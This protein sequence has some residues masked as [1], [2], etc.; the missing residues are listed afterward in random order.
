MVS[1]IEE[2]R[3][4]G[5]IMVKPKVVRDVGSANNALVYI[6]MAWRCEQETR[7][8]TIT[9]SRNRIWWAVK[10]RQM[11][12]ETGLN[13][14]QIR[15]SLKQLADAGWVEV[16]E[17]GPGLIRAYR[18]IGHVPT[19]SEQSD[20]PSDQSDSSGS[21]PSEQSDLL[22]SIETVAS[23]G[24]DKKTGVDADSEFERCYPEWFKRTERKRSLEMF[25]RVFKKHPGIADVVIEFGRAYAASGAPVDKTPSLAAWLNGERWTDPLPTRSSGGSGQQQRMDEDLTLLDRL[26]REEQGGGRRA[27]AS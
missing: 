6:R 7:G 14:E 4:A 1:F 13:V 10:H 12:E 3:T 21:G 25:R 2:A 27:I 22:L 26:R 15:Y 8:H 11:A 19:P 20:P 16:W 18:P 5:F 9:D 23:G 24:E 17:Q